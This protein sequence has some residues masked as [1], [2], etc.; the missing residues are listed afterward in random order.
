MGLDP[1][2]PGS[3]LEPKADIQSLSHAGIPLRLIIYQQ[4][5]QPRRNGLKTNNLSRL[6]HDYV[7]SMNRP[8][9]TKEIESIIKKLSMNKKVLDHIPSP[10]NS[11][12]HSNKINTKPSQ[13][14]YNFYFYCNVTA[15][16]N[17]MA[18]NTICCHLSDVRQDTNRLPTTAFALSVH[19][20][21]NVNRVK[22]ANNVLLLL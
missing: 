15:V 22:R 13:M 10:V 6:N 3:R 19:I 21:A 16:E 20:S 17:V 7:N 11:T 12:K 1:W 14:L 4:T 8:I 18:S 9:T 2:T 5:E